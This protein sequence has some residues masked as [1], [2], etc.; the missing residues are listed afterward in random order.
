M[1]EDA[2]DFPVI[3]RSGRGY[4]GIPEPPPGTRFPANP[5][6]NPWLA[7][8][9]AL[10]EARRGSFDNIPPVLDLYD[11]AA[12][13]PIFNFQVILLVGDA[14]PGGCFDKL[15]AELEHPE[16]PLDYEVGIN[17][18]RG[19]GIRGRLADLPLMA[20]TYEQHAFFD[21]ADIIPVFI[22]NLLESE[23]GKL[24]EPKEFESP[25]QYVA[26]VDERV[27]ELADEL[28]G[29]QV[30]VL[31]GERFSVRRLGELIL[32]QLDDPYF[33]LD[34]RRKFEAATGIDC[35]RFFRKEVLR[36]LAAAAIV[37]KFLESP[38]AATY[39]D[40]VRYFFGHR[41]PD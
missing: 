27:R 29:D 2:P 9:V 7:W 25:E 14:G 37:E 17:F 38:A 31:A 36:P 15:I 6:A 19:L 16:E 11:P 13:D 32:E 24:S 5:R 10:Y 20:R 41:I 34:Y 12:D 23:P 40:G 1:D 21:D 18:S 4:F 26:A 22:S 8:T 30:L 33:P 35:S 39:E 3:D 28:G